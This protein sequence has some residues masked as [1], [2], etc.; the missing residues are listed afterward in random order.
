MHKHQRIISA[1]LWHMRTTITLDDD[2]AV[3]LEKLRHS[4]GRTFKDVV[5]ETL[6]AGL[7]PTLRQEV[8]P[9]RYTQPR[10]LGAVPDIS[11]VSAVLAALDEEKYAYF[12]ESGRS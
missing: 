10:D 12:P 8:K 1:T 7:R 11:D 4:G 9:V 3:E 6:R 5:N 2:V